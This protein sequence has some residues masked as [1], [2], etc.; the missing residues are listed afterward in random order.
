M[1]IQYIEQYI[2]LIVVSMVTQN[3]RKGAG[4]ITAGFMSKG[5]NVD[6]SGCTLH[7]RVTRDIL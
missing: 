6:W 3:S 7:M 5:C 4:V 2:V 1:G